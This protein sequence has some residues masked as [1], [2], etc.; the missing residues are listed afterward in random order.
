[1]NAANLLSNHADRIGDI[2]GQ[3]WP[4]GVLG[5]RSDL[6]LNCRLGLVTAA[7]KWM[8][9]DLRRVISEFQTAKTN[10][11]PATAVSFNSDYV[12][13]LAKAKEDPDETIRE[14]AAL[15]LR[16]LLSVGRADYVFLPGDGTYWSV[17]EL[18][19]RLNRISPGRGHEH[20]EL[21]TAEVTRL[22]AEFLAAA[23]TSRPAVAPDQ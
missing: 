14:M 17:S 12:A 23:T 3:I 7:I 2:T 21:A 4:I 15:S 9:V 10:R 18:N 8:T 16:P 11:S 19:E 13:V 6:A 5:W 1:M 20:A 22:V